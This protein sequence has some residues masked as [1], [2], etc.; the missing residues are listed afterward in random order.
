[1]KT[2]LSKRAEQL[3]LGMASLDALSPLSVM[4]RGFSITEKASGEV[5]RDAANVKVGESLRVRLAKGNLKAEVRST[6]ME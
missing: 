4:N 6:E 5:V 2:L 3:G 1:M